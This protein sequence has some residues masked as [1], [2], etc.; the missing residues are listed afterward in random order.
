MFKKILVAMDSLETSNHILAAALF[1]AKTSNAEL[2]LLHVVSPYEEGYPNISIQ[3]GKNSQILT[4]KDSI[5]NYFKQRE[6]FESQSLELLRSHLVQAIAMGIKAEMTQNFGDPKWNICDLARTW[7]ADLI[8]MGRRASYDIKDAIHG[9][10][11]NYVLHNSHCA[12]LTLQHQ[13]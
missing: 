8:V 3:V 6:K 4:H 11:S 5:S 2:M 7:G 10:V 12:V 1:M 13:N 9:S